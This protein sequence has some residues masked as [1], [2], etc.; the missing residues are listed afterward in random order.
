MNPTQRTAQR[1]TDSNR[2]EA[3]TFWFRRRYADKHVGAWML[4]QNEREAQFLTSVSEAPRVGETLELTEPVADGEH[5]E[6]RPAVRLP[7]WGR[8]LWLEQG[9]G[10][11]RRVGI[12]F[13]HPPRSRWG[14]A[15]GRPGLPTGGEHRST[16][17]PRRT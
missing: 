9:A 3:F 2:S 17:P 10:R 6:T 12:R 7:R 5:P 13:E 15:A 16:S 1:K 14:N 4:R 11:T 8:V